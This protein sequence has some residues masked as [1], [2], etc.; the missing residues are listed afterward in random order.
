MSGDIGGVED[1]DT[2]IALEMTRGEWEQALHAVQLGTAAERASTSYPNA[3]AE[4]GALLVKRI[5]EALDMPDRATR[6][7]DRD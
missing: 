3:R 2:N 4:A 5:R 6:E 1:A 7:S